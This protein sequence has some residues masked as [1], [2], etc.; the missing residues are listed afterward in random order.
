MFKK[1]YILSSFNNDIIHENQCNGRKTE[2]KL[3][4]K[5]NIIQGLVNEKLPFQ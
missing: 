3:D 4:F 5:F 1:I 2:K